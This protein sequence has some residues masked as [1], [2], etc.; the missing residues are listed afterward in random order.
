MD[1]PHAEPRSIQQQRIPAPIPADDEAVRRPPVPE[2]RVTGA[3]DAGQ[4]DQKAYA[5][6]EKE[7]S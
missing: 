7:Q 6:K 4:V 1:T 3:G 2:A 5:A